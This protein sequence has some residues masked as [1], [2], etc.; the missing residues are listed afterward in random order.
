MSNVVLMAA[1]LA[2]AGAT[3]GAQVKTI[4]EETITATA[5][6]EAIDQSTRT[7]TIKDDQGVYDTIQ[8]PAEITKF[9]ALKV[10]DKITVRYYSSL[11][12]RLKKPG[13]AAVD[14][15][16][17]AVTPAG[18]KKP[19]GTVA[20]Q[21]TLTVTITAIDPKVPSITVK[22][23]NGWTYSRKVKDKK[24]LAQVKVGDKLDITWN[25][26]VLISVLPAK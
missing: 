16:T 7:L 21:R 15:D 10:G 5:T 13:E 22:S 2:A 14:V 4:P 11:I 3:I 19:G 1:M 8:A 18:G 26:A 24:A 20:S 9:S 12:V 6:I 23:D 25:D 17:A